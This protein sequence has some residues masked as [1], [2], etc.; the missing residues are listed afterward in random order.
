MPR[1]KRQENRRRAKGEGSIIKRPDGY[2]QASVLIG[3]DPQTGKP[4]RKYFIGKTE[5]EVKTKLNEVNYHL[6]RGTYADPGQINLGQWLTKWIQVYKNGENISPTTRERYQGLINSHII[7]EIGHI[8][9]SKIKTSDI[10]NFINQKSCSGRLDGKPGGLAKSTVKQ[11]YVILKAALDQATAPGE[12]LLH[13]NPADYVSLPKV[14]KKK[15]RKVYTSEA[16][17]EFFELA[18]QRTRLYP[19][20]VL[21]V[22]MGLRRSE[23]LGLRIKDINLENG[24]IK[25][26]QTTVRTNNGVQVKEFPK[27][28]HSNRT[29]PIPDSIVPILKDHIENLKQQSGENFKLK[30]LV[31]PTQNGNP[32]CPR[33]FS[34]R[35]E[36]L[37]KEMEKR[38]YPRLTLHDLR[39]S[40]ATL[41]LEAGVNIKIISSILGHHSAAFTMQTYIQSSETMEQDALEK[42]NKNI[43]KIFENNP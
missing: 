16:I 15:P 4:K 43:D 35:F 6:D 42:I 7:P 19:A 20:F 13:Y 8:K 41:M 27:T 30:S 23:I 29:I 36:V 24:F 1:K 17:K 18:K 3:Y 32:M 12:K 40:C 28:H 22:T 2:W 26:E 21:A 39:H 33:N 38:G 31:F 34:T 9:L 37:A 11:I 10:Q 14:H 25:I 5:G